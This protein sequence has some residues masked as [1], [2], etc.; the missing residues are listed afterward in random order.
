M[1]RPKCEI[2][3][4]AVSI[5]AFQLCNSI[6]FALHLLA[7]FFNRFCTLNH[8]FVSVLI[9]VK[10]NWKLLISQRNC[11]KK[12]STKDQERGKSYTIR[13]HH[14]HFAF[15][16]HQ[17]YFHRLYILPKLWILRFPGWQDI[18]TDPSIISQNI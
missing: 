9:P 16:W 10:A 5:C 1:M 2:I 13:C 7:S 15:W 11:T 3:L 18:A 8:G 4:G 12:F 6:A 17:K 14:N